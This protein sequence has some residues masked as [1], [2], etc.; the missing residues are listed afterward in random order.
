[1]RRSEI[2]D[3]SP[4]NWNEFMPQ[5][6]KAGKELL[7]LSMISKQPMSGYDLIKKIYAETNVLLSQGTLYPILYIFE[8]A[9]ILKAQYEMGNIRTKIY[10]LTPQ[11][12]E[13]AQDKIDN[14]IQA[15]NHFIKLIDAEASSRHMTNIHVL[16][17]ILDLDKSN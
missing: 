11:G 4:N 7:I 5:I 12:R 8:G 17:L 14:F 15:L 9:S 6:I 1:M 2:E 10:R 16:N 3:V 13:I